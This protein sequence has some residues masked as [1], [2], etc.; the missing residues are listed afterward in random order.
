MARNDGTIEREQ[1]QLAYQQQAQD[2]CD[3]ERLQAKV[4]R[5]EARIRKLE[6]VLA[7]Y[8]DYDIDSTAAQM[9]GRRVERSEFPFGEFDNGYQYK[10]NLD[11][12]ALQ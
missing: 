12:E 10:R 7:S 6:T 2:R 1:A 11:A 3:I 4:D 8:P 5:L 9:P